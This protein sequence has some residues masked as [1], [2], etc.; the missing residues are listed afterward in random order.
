MVRG[1]DSWSCAVCDRWGSKSRGFADAGGESWGHQVHLTM[2]PAIPYY[3]PQDSSKCW[4]TLLR[5]TAGRLFHNVWTTN[6]L[7]PCPFHDDSSVLRRPQLTSM[8]ILRSEK[9]IQ[10]GS[11]SGI[12][13]SDLSQNLTTSLLTRDLPI[14]TI[15]FNFVNNFWHILRTDRQT[16][17]QR[18][19][20]DRNTSPTSVTAVM[21]NKL[22]LRTL[23][24][25]AVERGYSNILPP[26]IQ[27][28]AKKTYHD[29][30]SD[31]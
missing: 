8:R 1:Y 6:E 30:N 25:N 9:M 2:K 18:D 29:K 27:G 4:L 13:E 20:D 10:P 26:H 23:N 11:R 24:G 28:A 31:F 15:W 3:W 7:G 19:G 22:I 17:R 16:D 12:Q 21:T 14:H 5:T